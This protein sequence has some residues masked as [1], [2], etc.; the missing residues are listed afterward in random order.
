MRHRPLPSLL[1]VLVLLA[2]ALGIH[3]SAAQ[4]GPNRVLLPQVASA[5]TLQPF[6]FDL[7][8]WY[9]QPNSLQFAKDALPRWVRAADIYWDKVEPEPG[10][11]HWEELAPIEAALATL[12]AQGI[13]PVVIVQHTPSWAQKYPGRTCSPPRPEH[14]DDWYR[15][16]QALADRYK[17]G[18][19][20]IRYWEVWN[21][22]ET[23]YEYIDDSQ[24]TGCWGDPNDPYYGGREYGSML[25]GATAALKRGNPQAQV[26]G[27]AL[28]YDPNNSESRSF[29]DGMAI[30]GGVAAIDLLSFHAYGE[31]QVADW[32]ITKTVN[33]REQLRQYGLA[34]KPLLATEVGAACP[35]GNHE[36]CDP[37]TPGNEFI[38]NEQG[39]YA[40]RIYAES[41]A[42]GLKGAFWYTFIER[43]PGFAY[44]N[45]IDLNASDMVPRPAYYA[46]RNS[47]RLLQDVTYIG[48]PISDPTN[49]Q[50]GKVRVLAFQKPGILMYVL[51]VQRT[52]CLDCPV[53][54]NIAVPQGAVARCT[55]NLDGRKPGG[56]DGEP[57]YFNCSD[58]NK[59]G[60]I[61]RAVGELPQYIEIS[62]LK[63]TANIVNGLP[64]GPP[65]R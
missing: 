56:N 2:S 19:S 51:W 3:S 43:P 1:L 61:P 4:S 50:A 20:A 49:D 36:I 63:T 62:T 33:I 32:L 9:L 37:N 8:W 60:V 14:M 42:L 17:D 21:E 5:P 10:V 22:P 40:A 59:D 30:S 45:L 26:I 35:Q 11:Y 46:F 18:P 15:F 29:L 27:G 12:H 48:P 23:Y 34:D 44:S 47:A 31:W 64:T 6:G 39:N 55:T 13:E 25:I 41:I 65:G 54:Y 52:E 7:R 16:L 38:N 24:G 57:Y 53:L 58:T 28:V